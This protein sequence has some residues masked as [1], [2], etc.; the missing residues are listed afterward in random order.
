MPLE[1]EHHELAAQAP[2]SS[3][4]AEAGGP[5]EVD[6]VGHEHAP[7]GAGD[8]GR[9]EVASALPAELFNLSG[10]LDWATRQPDPETRQ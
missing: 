9:S 2:V 5:R 10:W 8:P 6:A 1:K 4:V 7:P 3:S